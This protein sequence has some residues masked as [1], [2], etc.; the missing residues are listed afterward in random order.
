ML[1]GYCDPLHRQID[2]LNLLSTQSAKQGFQVESCLDYGFTYRVKRK[3]L[4]C[5]VGTPMFHED[6][7][8]TRRA[9]DESSLGG[10]FARGGR[11]RLEDSELCVC[12]K[13]AAPDRAPTRGEFE[14]ELKKVLTGSNPTQV[15]NLVPFSCDA[16]ITNFT[17]LT[18][19]SRA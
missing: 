5:G 15:C 16:G 10:F 4:G 14:T 18:T 6:G 13:N 1:E 8:G 19:H 17:K 2:E 12:D 11:R 7:N 3:R 9:L